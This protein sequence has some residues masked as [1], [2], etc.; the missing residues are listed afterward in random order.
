MMMIA[1]AARSS[2]IARGRRKTRRRGGA[3]GARAAAPPAAP[4][5]ARV[6]DQVD[7]DRPGDPAERRQQR[8]PEP[9]VLAQLAEV[10]LAFGLQPDDEEEERHQPLVAPA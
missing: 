1:S 8:V 9:V 2:K 10:D 5:A 3:G 7:A 6:E 4:R